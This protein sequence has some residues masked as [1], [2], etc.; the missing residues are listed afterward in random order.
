MSS[1]SEPRSLILTMTGGQPTFFLGGN[2]GKVVTVH[3][4]DFPHMFTHYIWVVWTINLRR[5]EEIL[6]QLMVYPIIYRV[7]TIR[8]VVRISQSSTEN[9]SCMALWVIDCC[10]TH[11][12]QVWP[13]TLKW[14]RRYRKCFP[15]NGRWK[16]SCTRPRCKSHGTMDEVA[17]DSRD[18][19]QMCIYEW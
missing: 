15:R 11:I 12:I 18:H 4:P 19:N 5:M 17:S 6:H 9:G 13:G 2:V 10:F 1:K 16:A 8:L 7:L 3:I 14:L